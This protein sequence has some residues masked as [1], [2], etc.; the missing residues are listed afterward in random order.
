VL[1]S[2]GVALVPE[3]VASTIEEAF[4]AARK[5]G[6]PAVVKT[7]AAGAHKSETGGVALNLRDEE[8]VRAA[9]ERI[10]PPVL[11]QPFL[12]GG[13]ELLAGVVQD[14]VFGPLVAFGPGGVLAELIADVAFR[15]APLTDVDADELVHG[16]KAGRLVAGWRGA[17]A[18]DGGALADLLYRLSRLSEELP[19]IAELD[20]NPVLASEH[21]CVAVDARVRGARPVQPQSL[22][23]W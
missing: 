18:A 14:P 23:G 1:E 5:L 10:G 7:A 21:G 22:Q 15:I 20:L 12:R 8:A 3:A 11:V 19:E 4:A 6:F 17:P 16:G 13:A 9:V 2:Y